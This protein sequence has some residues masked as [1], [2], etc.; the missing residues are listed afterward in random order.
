VLTRLLAGRI[1]VVHEPILAG[2]FIPLIVPTKAAV[3]LTARVTV[4]IHY[5]FFSMKLASVTA[6]GVNFGT[7]SYEIMLRYQIGVVALAIGGA[8]RLSV[9]AWLRRTR[10]SQRYR[11]LE[12]PARAAVSVTRIPS[13]VE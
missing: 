2:G 6:E 3:Q 13:R 7:V 12:P 10:L 9:D 11:A 8:A 4:H 5:G 1:A